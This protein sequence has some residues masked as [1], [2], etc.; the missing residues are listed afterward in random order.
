MKKLV[1]ICEKTLTFYED[2]FYFSF[3]LNYFNENKQP[4]NM[5]VQG[6]I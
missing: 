6:E 3:I 5:I 2:F 4:V 1:K